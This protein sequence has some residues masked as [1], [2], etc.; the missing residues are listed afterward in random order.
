MI[1]TGRSTL[2]TR[3]LSDPAGRHPWSACEERD[4]EVD[5]VGELFA[6]SDPG[7]HPVLAVV[8]PIVAQEE[9]VGVVELARALE[10]TYD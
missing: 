8:E 9:H 5:L 1:V 6:A 2:P 3:L 10:M 4:L 7:R